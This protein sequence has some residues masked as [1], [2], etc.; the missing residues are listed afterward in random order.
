MD[1]KKITEYIFINDE[2][3]SGD[4][5]FVF[6]T[7]K[8]L[9]KSVEHT[10]NI[11]KNKLVK[12]V[13]FTGGINNEFNLV[14]SE[15]MRNIAIQS[16]ITPHDILIEDKSTNTLENVLFSIPILEKEIG[17]NNIKTITAI[18]K[19]YHSRRALMTL[20]KH[21]PK[22]IK[23]KASAYDSEDDKFGKDVWFE[24]DRGEKKIT[25]ELNKIKTY[26]VKGDLE[27]I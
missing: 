25:E 8:A 1:I 19:N 6:G 15:E 4:I 5:A 18:V 23:L 17:L 24:S 12:K 9:E 21:L 11:Y 14:E 27:E 13:I 3:P 7:Y 2:N 10:V 22:H 20:K 26:L 16:G